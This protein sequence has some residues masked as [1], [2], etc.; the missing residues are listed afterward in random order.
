MV[1]ARFDRLRA[2]D[3]DYVA[4]RSFTY[5]GKDYAK[6]DPFPKDGLS[7]H[8]LSKLHTA[9]YIDNAPEVKPEEQVTVNDKGGGNYEITAPWLTEPEKVKGKDN[10]AK[11]ADEIRTAGPPLGFMEGGSEVTVEGGEGGWHTISAPWLDEPEKVQGREAAESRQREI[12]AAGE[13]ATHHG[14]TLQPGENGWHT[15]TREGADGELKVQGVDAAREAAAKLRA[16]EQVEGQPAEWDPK[17]EPVEGPA[18]S[19]LVTEVDGKFI[20]TAPW[21]APE[22]FDAAEAAEA[23]QT[24]IRTAGPPDGWEPEGGSDET[25][26]SQNK[27]AGGEQPPAS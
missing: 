17:I 13:P 16:G 27:E 11:R 22:A 12:H 2:F 23:R 4:M 21:Q 24:E 3:R 6:G 9:R 25:E 1:R 15:I 8:D 14:V 5:H 10:A 7:H 20:V 18:A 19:V 26:E